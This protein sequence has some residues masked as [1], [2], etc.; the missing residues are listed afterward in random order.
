MLHVFTCGSK[1]LRIAT[2]IGLYHFN[3]DWRLSLHPCRTQRIVSE[4]S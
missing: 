4:D 2:E 3:K 1:A